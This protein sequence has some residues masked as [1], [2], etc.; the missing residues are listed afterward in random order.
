MM[1]FPRIPFRLCDF[2]AVSKETL[3]RNGDLV[4]RGEVMPGVVALARFRPQDGP[5][6][7]WKAYSL[8]VADKNAQ[9]S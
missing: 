5:K 7:S 9:T 4:V 8:S 6:G 1:G 2:W 3:Q